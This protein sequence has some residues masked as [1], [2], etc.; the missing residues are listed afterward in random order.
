MEPTDSSLGE[1]SLKTAMIQPGMFKEGPFS[2]PIPNSPIIPG[3]TI[4]RRRTACINGLISTP[5]EGVNTVY[6]VLVLAAERYGNLNAM[7]ERKLIKTHYETKMVKKTVE[8]KEKLVE[9][10]WTFFEMGGFEYLS[11]REYVA[12]TMELGAG[13]RFLGLEKE[14]RV[15]IFAATR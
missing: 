15:H 8:G 12:L 1:G 6:D 5:E 7:G 4:P 11:F 2:L 9:K 14:D 3:E 13:L 10:K